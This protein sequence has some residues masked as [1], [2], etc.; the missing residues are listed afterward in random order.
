[1]TAR[2]FEPYPGQPMPKGSAVV[3]NDIIAFYAIHSAAI[4][5]ISLSLMGCTFVIG[6]S[7]YLRSFKTLYERFPLYVAFA[8]LMFAATHIGDHLQVVVTMHYPS[9]TYCRLLGVLV[10]LGWGYSMLVN[11]S[12]AAQCW[13]RTVKHIHLD[14][15]AYEW[16]LQALVLTFLT[17]L[18]SV[19]LAID[20]FGVGPYYIIFKTTS[21]AGIG[22]WIFFGNVVVP[23][24]ASVSALAGYSTR[25]HIRKL[26]NELN[27]YVKDDASLRMSTHTADLRMLNFIIVSLLQYVPVVFMTNMML[28]NDDERL[29]N[30]VSYF[31]GVLLGNSGGAFNFLVYMMN[32][33]VTCG[34]KTSKEEGRTMREPVPSFVCQAQWNK[35]QLPVTRISGDDI[36]TQDA[37]GEQ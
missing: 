9:P 32:E 6:R 5:A 29:A 12:L 31:I 23:A 3:A 11:A 28:F 1:M 14:L 27:S 10:A 19:G 4:F 21:R 37:W 20:A 33:Q 34:S 26:L 22:I 35:S 18:I 24:V 7:L 13:L 17:L 16:K 8:D 25:K 2:V 36:G 30:K 15:G